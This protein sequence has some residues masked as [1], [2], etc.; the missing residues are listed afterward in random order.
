MDTDLDSGLLALMTKLGRIK[1]I[2]EYQGMVTVI[3]IR[4]G[5][6]MSIS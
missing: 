4:K 3:R 2:S 1:D 6:I 5:L